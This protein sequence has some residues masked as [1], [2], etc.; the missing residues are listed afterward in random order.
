MQLLIQYSAGVPRQSAGLATSL[1]LIEKIPDRTN[2]GVNTI[3]AAV[4]D[5]CR[6]WAKISTYA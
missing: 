1:A 3:N 2:K 5:Q 6:S 4:F